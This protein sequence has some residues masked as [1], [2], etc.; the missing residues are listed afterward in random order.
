M[1][2]YRCRTLLL[3]VLA[4]LVAAV[5]AVPEARASVIGD[6]ADAIEGTCWVC[7][8]LREVANVGLDLGNTIFGTLASSVRDL[9]AVFMALWIVLLAARIF[10]PFGPEGGIGDLWNKAAKKLMVLALVL[11]FLQSSQAFWDYIFVPVVGA[12]MAF[13]GDVARLGPGGASACTAPTPSA[14]GVAAAK[15]IMA[16]LDCPLTE[17]QDAFGKGVVVGVAIIVRGTS[18]SFW[19]VF[20]IEKVVGQ[21][22]LVICGLAVVGVYLVGMILFPLAI[23]D[24][25]MRAVVIATLSPLLIAGAAFAWTRG[26]T[27]AALRGLAHSGL[28]LVMVAIVASLGEAGILFLFNRL[29]FP[30]WPQLRNGLENTDSIPI[31]SF[32]YWAILALGV[33]L[34][35]MM[36]RANSMA[37]EFTK[38]SGGDF[39]GAGSGTFTAAALPVTAAVGGAAKGA[40]ALMKRR[41]SGG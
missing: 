24:V 2:S 40:R 20:R 14:T 7:D 34:L 30:D 38:S 6:V 3:A 19:D 29:G 8:P 35:F 36:K 41:A 1:T 4:M 5:G 16:G 12:G 39:T 15:Q 13:A 26:A 23:V 33:I 21:I 10:L 32:D 31:W 28:T 37:A 22:L 18:G 9:V 11:G 27:E 17:V 25:V